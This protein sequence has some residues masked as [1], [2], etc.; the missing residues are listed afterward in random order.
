M[1]CA[2]FVAFAGLAALVLYLRARL[3]ESQP[4]DYR[5]IDVL[6]AARGLR[7]IAVT[8]DDDYWR[9]WLRGRLSLSNCAR[10]YVAVG[11]DPDGARRELHVA[12]DPWQL[13]TVEADVLLEREAS[14]CYGDPTPVGGPTPASDPTPAG[15]PPA[16]VAEFLRQR[17]ALD[18]A[19]RE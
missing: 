3:L 2:V 6:L 19:K 4:S 8:R 18:R 10:I 9:Y 1:A 15:A 12:F 13:G 5:A 7:P 14:V 17:E 16:A 11:E